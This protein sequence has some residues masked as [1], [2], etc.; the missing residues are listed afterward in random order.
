ME[1]F[2]ETMKKGMRIR[3][4]MKGTCRRLFGGMADASADLSNTTR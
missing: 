2:V 4:K 1:P 3:R